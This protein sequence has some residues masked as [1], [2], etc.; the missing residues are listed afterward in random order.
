MVMNLGEKTNRLLI[1]AVAC[2]HV[3]SEQYWLI[4]MNLWLVFTVCVLLVAK[5]PDK[6]SGQHSAAFL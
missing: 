5:R 3:E 6:V 2:F 1:V 4:V